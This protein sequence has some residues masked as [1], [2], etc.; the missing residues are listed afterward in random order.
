[1]VNAITL[2]VEGRTDEAVGKRLLA[3]AGIGTTAVYGLKGKHY[4]DEKLAGYNNAARFSSWL[5]LRD[6]NSDEACAP[7]LRKRLLPSPA[8]LARLHIVVRAVEAWLLADHETLGAFLRVPSRDLPANPDE[9]P[10]PKLALIEIARRSRRKAI[11]GG[12]LPAPGST[13]SVG[14]GYT[15]MIT[16]FATRTWRPRIAAYRSASLGRLLRHLDRLQDTR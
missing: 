7:G 11:L 13:A 16:E 14:P 8:P 4:L 10:H 5:I 12:F 1:M 9:L 15:A 3:D 2:A 6:L